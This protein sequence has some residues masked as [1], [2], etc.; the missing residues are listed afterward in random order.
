[1]LSKIHKG[2]QGSPDDFANELWKDDREVE[3]MVRSAEPTPNGRVVRAAVEPAST[4]NTP[5]LLQTLV[6]DLIVLLGV[7]GAEV[8][9]QTLRFSFGH[10]AVVSVPAFLA[11]AVFASFVRE[12]SPAPIY[13]LQLSPLLLELDKITA[14]C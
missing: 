11:D 1:M 5:D 6:A 2:D 4:T 13:A 10:N 3:R 8:L 7:A 14:L 12:G 9:A